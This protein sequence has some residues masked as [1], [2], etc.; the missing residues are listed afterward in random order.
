MPSNFFASFWRASLHESRDVAG[1]CTWGKQLVGGEAPLIIHSHANRWN[2][3]K[4]FSRI[5]L[6]ATSEPLHELSR[7]KVD[8]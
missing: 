3:A 7:G 6:Q 5:D 4:N 8:G 1:N 2:H